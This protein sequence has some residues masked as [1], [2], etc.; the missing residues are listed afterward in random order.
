MTLHFDIETDGLL[1]AM[2]RVVCLS[3]S[4][5]G[6]EPVT[7]HEPEDIAEVIRSM[8]EADTVVGHNIIGFDIP[9]LEKVFG[10]IDFKGCIRDTLVMSRLIYPEIRN[11]EHLF[12]PPAP[13]PSTLS[14]SHSLEAWGYRLGM[15]KDS[16]LSTVSDFENLKYSEDLRLYCEQDVRVTVALFEHLTN[17][18]CSDTALILEHDFAECIAKQMRNGF[19]F[20]GQAASSL[21]VK[22][23]E[24]RDRLVD[25][26]R[27]LVP[28]TEIVLKTK[29]KHAPFNPS[30]RQQIAKALKLLCNWE[31]SEYTPSGEAK[32]DESVLKDIDH[33]VAA[34]LI[35]YLTVAKRI[36]MLA[37]GVEAWLRVE[38][39]GRIY[40]Y[41]NHNGAVTGRCTH[42]GPNMAQV[43]ASHSPYGKECRSLFIAEPGYSLLGV[44]ASGLELR[45]LAHYMARYDEGEY[46]KEIL[47]GDIHTKNQKAAGLSTRDQAKLFIYA[48]LYGAGPAK[49]GSIIGGG[50]SDG[51]ALKNR[52]LKK[53]PALKSLQDDIAFA[54]EARGNLIGVDGRTLSV[55]SKH[56]ALNTLLQSAGA[57][58]M[59]QATVIMNRELTRSG[60]DYRQVAH[61]H[62]EVQFEVRSSQAQDA[63]AIVQAAIP[64]AGEFLGF[65]CPLAGEARVGKN[66]AETH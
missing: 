64:E 8:A 18:S 36:G 63:A 22:L 49:L 50:Y 53:I 19:A 35:E 60:I 59:K 61:I 24:I 20:D 10:P 11:N 34:M 2:T 26:L 56:S 47:N 33:P 3:Y 28:P 48:F 43:P 38:N 5:N 66:W 51:Q 37:E 39:K 12:S 4:L 31:P 54:I 29:T 16:F 44:D 32:V 65:R 15:H 1:D 42:R 30:S 17:H 9:A 45:C 14:G 62:D 57:I 21:Y 46:A 40:G 25:D 27:E 55:R 23:F 52:F 41:V 13:V 58:V 6:N 7:V